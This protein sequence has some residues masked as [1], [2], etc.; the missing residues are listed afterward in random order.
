MPRYLYKCQNC[1]I[2]F[3]ANHSIKEKLKD[4]ENCQSA[5]TLQRIP[6]IPFVIDKGKSEDKRPTGA[7]VKEYIEDVRD[8][9]NQEKKDLSS[10]VYDD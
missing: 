2:F 3:Q 1:E 7:L 8:E 4:C 6:S 9:L 10:Q 5:D